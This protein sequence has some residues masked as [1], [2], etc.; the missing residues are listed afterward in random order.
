[1]VDH[2]HGAC[3]YFGKNPRL[4]ATTSAPP[5]TTYAA[6]HRKKSLDNGHFVFQNLLL[7]VLI[8]VPNAAQILHKRRE[9]ALA[10]A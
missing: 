4:A 7:L 5:P 8:W 3:D 1:M 10:P 9:E 6:T 2:T